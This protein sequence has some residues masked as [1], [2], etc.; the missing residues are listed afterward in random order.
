[1]NITRRPYRSEDCQRIGQFLVKHYQPDNQ[2]GNWLRPT[3][4][5]MHSHPMLDESVLERIAVWEDEGEIV[6]VAHYESMLGEAF[7]E[8]HPD[9]IFLK[10]EMLQY[11]EENLSRSEN[12]S[13]K[14]RIYT[15]DFDTEFE[16]LV[17][18]TGYH[19]LDK[20]LRPLSQLIIPTEIPEAE[21]PVGF[22]VLSLADENDLTKIN[23][24]LWRGFNH[25][26][27]PPKEEE[28][29]RKKMQS[30]PNFRKDLTIVVADPGGNFRAFCGFWFVPENRYGVIEPLATDP[31]FRRMGLA[32]AGVWEG[33]RRCRDLG[34]ETIYVGSDL[35]FYLALGFK[36]IYLT[37]PWI[38]ES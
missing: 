24:V 4:D 31:D 15:N 17:S 23:Q 9:Y 13:K 18:E 14:L 34:A 16:S 10:S 26:G 29:G 25:P 32:K 2:D 36:P 30:S 11:A 37:R 12:E 19:L 21:L 8:C 3:W 1:M 5:Y 7:F 20:E 35:P 27:E 38:K 6:G 33:V 22:R 28:A